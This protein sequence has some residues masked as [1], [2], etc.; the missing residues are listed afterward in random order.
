MNF[1]RTSL[2]TAC[3]A[4]G[5]AVAAEPALAANPVTTKANPASTGY[6][7]GRPWQAMRLDF[8]T[9]KQMI[10]DL[11][12]K[13]DSL[14]GD[15]SLVQEEIGFIH[16]DIAALKNRLDVQISVAPSAERNADND[17]PV[18]VF[19]HVTHN[20]E[21]VTGLTADNFSYNNAFP[22]AGAVFCGAAC[23][24][25]GDAGVYAITLNGDWS[26]TS[27]AGALAVA[28][29]VVAA[30]GEDIISNG[31]SLVSFDIPAAPAAPEVVP[32]AS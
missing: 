30:D 24:S 22:A 20:G 12:F 28:S 10:E 1:N 14:T 23:F 8:L 16:D 29:T 27:Y 11:D 19:V 2:L 7:N 32:P 17:A 31:S 18:T 3:I 9:V 4:L 26:A 6:P 13:F 15:A 5:V 21:A 25:A